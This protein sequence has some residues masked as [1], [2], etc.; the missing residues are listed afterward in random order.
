MAKNIALDFTGTLTDIEETNMQEALRVTL[1]R[2]GRGHEVSGA[3]KALI[4][5]YGKTAGER[6]SDAALVELYL[7]NGKQG[8][9]RADIGKAVENSFRK[10]IIRP[11]V[12]D[13]LVDTAAKGADIFLVS[14]NSSDELRDVADGVREYSRKRG[15]PS[16]VISDIIGVTLDY[17][18]AI[19]KIIS[20]KES[21]TDGN[22][23]EVDGVRLVN[24][25]QL[26]KRLTDAKFHYISDEKDFDIARMAQA[27]GHNA[28]L[29]RHP[30]MSQWPQGRRRDAYF[31]LAD[32]YQAA[33]IESGAYNKIVPTDKV[34]ELLPALLV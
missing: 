22:A 3:Y 18:P 30:S 10:G 17:D 6:G 20:V 24:K 33:T 9:T 34:R 15:G 21:I 26:V 28:I 32:D 8:M 19:G 12:L 27:S 13:V 23:T 4:D 1:E 14:K 11:D 2:Q 7:T 29:I 16:Q 31:S 5:Q 25:A